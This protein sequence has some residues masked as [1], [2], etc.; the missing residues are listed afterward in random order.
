[1]NWPF[2]DLVGIEIQCRI[3]SLILSTQVVIEAKLAVSLAMASRFMVSG[4][5]AINLGG[6]SSTWTEESATGGQ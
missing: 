4:L 3:Y 6:P 1:M 2:T 5:T